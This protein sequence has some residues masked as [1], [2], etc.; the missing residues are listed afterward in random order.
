[1]PYAIKPER[2]NPSPVP[3]PR[4]VAHRDLSGGE[5]ASVSALGGQNAPASLQVP[6]L[7]RLSDRAIRKSGNVLPALR[8]HRACRTLLSPEADP[9]LSSC[10]R[11]SSNKFRNNRLDPENSAYLGNKEGVGSH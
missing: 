6:A 9:P 11:A 3:S 8:A 1:M 5:P 2:N 4:A 10:L 7:M